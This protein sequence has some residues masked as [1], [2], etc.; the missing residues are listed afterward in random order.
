MQAGGLSVII[1]NWNTR[2]L[3]RRCLGSLQGTVGNLELEIVVVDNGST[4]G[5]LEMVRSEFPAVKLLPQ[6]RNLGFA[7]AVNLGVASSGC[8]LVLLLNSDTI[9]PAGCLQKTVAM[10]EGGPDI[11]VLGCCLEDEHG[12]VQASCG[13]FPSVW[14]MWWQNL[15][16]LALK[17]V[18]PGPV[19]FLSRISG[20]PLMPLRDLMRLWDPAGVRD[21]DWVSGAFLLTRREVFERVGSLDEAFWLFGEDMDWCWR[22]RRSGGRVVYFGEARIVHVGGGST[23][24]EVESDLRHYRASVQLYAKHRGAVQTAVYRS[25]LSLGAF[26]RLLGLVLARFIGRGGTGFRSRVAR[27]WGLMTLRRGFPD[28]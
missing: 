20:V 8:R 14:S 12:K 17:G 3:L 18:G 26:V 15:F 23:V 11:E 9:V 10:V 16:I 4:D 25:V 28:G 2:D 27:E 13:V 6:T 19:R 24:A 21:V 22:V 5:S 7:K 1:V